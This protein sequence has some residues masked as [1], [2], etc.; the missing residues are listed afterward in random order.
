MP[1]RFAAPRVL[2]G[3]VPSRRLGYSLGVDILPFKTCSMDCVYCQLGASARTTV[4][5]R[6]FVSSRT[7][8]AQIRAALTSGARIDVITFSGSGE[9]TLNA[10]LGRIIRGIKRMTSIPVVV[11]TNSSHLVRPEVRR[12]LRSADIVVPSLDAAAEAAFRKVNRPHSGLTAAA[13][14]D[15]LEAFRR[16]FPGRIWLEIM[17]VRGLNDKPAH[18]AALKA[19]AARIRPDR[20][21]LNTVVRPPAERR[22]KPLDREEL[23]RIRDYFGEGAEIIAD[24]RTPARPAAGGGTDEGEAAVLAIVGRRPVTAADLALTLGLPPAEAS[25]LADRLAAAGKVRAVPHA[26]TTYYEKA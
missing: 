17:L 5:R 21:Q 12:E 11:L 4:R 24:F 2:Y 15:G 23:E 25:A 8:L 19:A 16:E 14:V 3:P 7:V 13:I 20:I 10:A 22:A 26:G 9:P 1:E 18:L 6:E